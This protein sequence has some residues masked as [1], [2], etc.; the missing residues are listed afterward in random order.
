LFLIVPDKKFATH[1]FRL[2]NRQVTLNSRLHANGCNSRYRC[3]FFFNGTLGACLYGARYLEK[4][5]EKDIGDKW[6][7]KLGSSIT[8]WYEANDLLGGL[9]WDGTY[10]ADII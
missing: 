6:T 7:S 1:P 2:Y 10:Y 4:F 5:H 9:Y 8:I 3:F